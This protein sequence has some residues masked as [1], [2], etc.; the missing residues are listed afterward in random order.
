MSGS[1]GD[2]PAGDG[3]RVVPYA[4]PFCAEETLRPVEQGRWHCRSCCRVFSLTFH[5]LRLPARPAA[6]QHDAPASGAG[7]STVT[8]STTERSTA[9]ATAGPSTGSTPAERNL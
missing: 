6:G 9:T 4:C 2:A 3:Q 1:E 5:E 7:S 8:A